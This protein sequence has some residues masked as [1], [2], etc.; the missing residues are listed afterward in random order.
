MD[1]LYD[2]MRGKNCTYSVYDSKLNTKSPFIL[3]IVKL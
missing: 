1:K 3:L 2:I